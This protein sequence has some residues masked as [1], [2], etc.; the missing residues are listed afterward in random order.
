PC[1]CSSQKGS[2][3]RM[4]R[5]E[6]RFAATASGSSPTWLARLNESYDPPLTP[7]L[8]V[9]TIAFTRSGTGQS[10]TMKS[11]DIGFRLAQLAEKVGEILRQRRLPVHGLPARRMNQAQTPGMKRLP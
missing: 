7:P 10:G 5:R 6:A 1:T 9:V 2:A 11:G 4:A 8:R 3:G